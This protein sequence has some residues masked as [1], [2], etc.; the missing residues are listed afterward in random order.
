MEIKKSMPCVMSTHFTL[1]GEIMDVI[2]SGLNLESHGNATFWN[3]GCKDKL[4][5]DNFHRLLTV[6][7]LRHGK[8]SSELSTYRCTSDVLCKSFILTEN[9]L[10]VESYFQLTVLLPRFQTSQ[11]P[12]YQTSD[13]PIGWILCPALWARLIVT[14][15]SCFAGYLTSFMVTNMD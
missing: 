5:Y 12:T 10:T 4:E 2:S 6:C 7:W 3:Q 9:M 14:S 15:P 13:S 11:Q 8:L 1:F